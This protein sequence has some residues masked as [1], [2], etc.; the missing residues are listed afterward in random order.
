MLAGVFTHIHPLDVGETF[1]A[2]WRALYFAGAVWVLGQ[3]RVFVTWPGLPRSRRM[4]M[5][6]LSL[7]IARTVFVNVERWGGPIY[8]EGLPVDTAALVLAYLALRSWTR[9]PG[10]PHHA[11]RT[12]T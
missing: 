3:M 10:G 5:L 12:G 9:E 1:A 8:W 11:D 6:S 7:L 4:F 2:V